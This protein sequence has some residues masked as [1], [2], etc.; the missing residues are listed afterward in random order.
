MV[1]MNRITAITLELTEDCNLRC[2]YCFTYGKRKEKMTIETA[3]KSIDWL[4]EQSKDQPRIDV[5]FWGGEPLTQ[6]S[7]VKEIVEYIKIETS[8]AN[9]GYALS[10]TTN[11]TLLS[12]STLKYLQDENILFSVSID[13]REEVHNAHRPFASGKGSYKSVERGIKRAL[14]YFPELNLRLSLTSDKGYMLADDIK[15]FYSE[16]GV[17]NFNF[18]P[19][20]EHDWTEDKLQIVEEQFKELSEFT[21]EEMEKGNELLIYPFRYGIERLLA[22]EKQLPCGAGRHYVGISTEGAIYPCH[23]FHKFSDTRKWN[24]QEFCIGH[25][26]KG[27]TRSD[28]RQMFYDYSI[29]NIEKCKKCEIYQYCVGHCYSSCLD[30]VGD[31]HEFNDAMCTWS[32]LVITAAKFLILNLE[33]NNTFKNIYMRHGNHMN[34]SN[35]NGS[36][37]CNAG[38]Y[39]NH[40]CKCYNACYQDVFDYQ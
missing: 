14:K 20:W 11:G 9:K 7:L 19:V 34:M 6:L 31:M 25:I 16:W 35:R 30:I 23:R 33:E 28:T 2:D 39:E 4:I 29:D 8:K 40:G 38:C 18:S 37:D 10:M 1:K 26:D 13:G 32:K 15:Y 22:T 5:T 36:C 27:I 24:E 3:K 21:I 12:E 17:K